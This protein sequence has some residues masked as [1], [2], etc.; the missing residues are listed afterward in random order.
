MRL[1][2]VCIVGLGY[3]GLTLA[4]VLAQK[5]FKVFGIEKNAKLVDQLNR[6]QPHFHERGLPQ[7]LQESLSKNLFISQQLPILDPDAFIIAVGTPIDKVTKKPILEPLISAS[8]EV[9][10]N[11]SDGALV[12]LRST[13]PVGATRKIVKPILDQSGKSYFLAFCPERTIEGEA[14]KEL[15]ELPQIIGGLN[16]ESV[17]RAL[18]LFHNI[19]PTT[20]RVDSLETAEIIKLLNNSYRDLIFSFS[21]EIA[22]LSEKLGL[23]AVKVINAA[24]FGY[25]RSNIPRPGFV[26]GACLEKDPHILIDFANS[27]GYSPNLIKHSRKINEL[28]PDWVSNR[29]M[30]DLNKLNKNPKEVKILIS[31]FAFKGYPETDDIRGS[32]TIR[33]WENL[34]N[35]FNSDNIYGHDFIVK[36]NIFENLNIKKVEL[37][38]GFKDADCVILA[39]N[40]PKYQEMDIKRLISLMR[41]PSLLWDCWHHFGPDIF[42]DI[43]DVFYYSLGYTPQTFLLNQ[44]KLEGEEKRW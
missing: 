33:L 19:T 44:N 30:D 13:I 21:N 1:R 32:L 20:I 38:E 11:L 42:Q 14:L 36:D 6:G 3:V 34:K 31:G 12:I 8:W 29:I 40:H 18:D 15:V 2:N 35:I 37:E 28:L 7:L 17:D 10:K 5:K 24:N 41:K 16:E 27:L 25:P 26:G 23:D 39:N 9:S 22:L 4:V 43:G